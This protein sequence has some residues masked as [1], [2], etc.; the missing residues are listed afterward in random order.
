MSEAPPIR[1]RSVQIV[2]IALLAA[3]GANALDF[4]RAIASSVGLLLI[5]C[6]A[7]LYPRRH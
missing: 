5:V 7:I 1:R 4:H 3:M 2:V 6:G